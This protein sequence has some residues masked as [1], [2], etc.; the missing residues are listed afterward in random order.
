MCCGPRAQWG[1]AL[2]PC[3]PPLLLTHTPT[4]RGLI[5]SASVLRAGVAPSPLGRGWPFWAFP[6]ATLSQ[7]LG[8]RWGIQWQLPQKLAPQWEMGSS[9]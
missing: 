2:G 8:S 7:V 9:L 4:Q 6:S 1:G 5:S 3:L